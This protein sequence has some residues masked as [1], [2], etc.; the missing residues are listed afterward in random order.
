MKRVIVKA[1]ESFVP[2]NSAGTRGLIRQAFFSSCAMKLTSS[3][4]FT[5]KDVKR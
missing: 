2:E 3:S 4:C 1:A 5:V